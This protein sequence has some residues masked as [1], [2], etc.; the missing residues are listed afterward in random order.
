M[1]RS[2][3]ENGDRKGK[4]ETADLCETL[5]ELRS[6]SLLFPVHVGF[7]TMYIKA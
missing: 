4:A 5:V 6:E 7:C 3:S 2:A 1:E